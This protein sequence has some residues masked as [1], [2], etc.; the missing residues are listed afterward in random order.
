[1]SSTSIELTSMRVFI[2]ILEYGSEIL[3]SIY[4]P[5]FEKT[6]LTHNKCHLFPNNAMLFFNNAMLT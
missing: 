3:S 6:I 5:Y 1:M 4:L 2:D